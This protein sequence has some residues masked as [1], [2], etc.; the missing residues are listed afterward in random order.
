MTESQPELQ[1]LLHPLVLVLSR[2][3]TTYHSYHLVPFSD[4]IAS[5]LV[6]PIIH[7]IRRVGSV[8]LAYSPLTD[9]G[10]S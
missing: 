10:E 2:Y 1:P 9:C 8:L 4:D 6:Y 5:T 7:S 3:S